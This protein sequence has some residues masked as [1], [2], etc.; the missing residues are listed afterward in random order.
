MIQMIIQ[1]QWLDQSPLINIP[2]FEDGELIVKLSKI[3]VLYIPQLIHRIRGDIKGFFDNEVRH[4]L[5]HEDL[6]EIVKAL[7]KVP[8]VEMKYSVTATNHQEEILDREVLEEGGDAIVSVNLRRTNKYNRQFVS[9]SN[10]PKPKECS[11]FLLIGNKA[12]NE[13]LAM[14]RIAFKRY[15]S[16]NLQICLPRSFVNEQLSIILMCDS[17]LGLDQEYEI[18]LN[19]INKVIRAKNNLPETEQEEEWVDPEEVVAQSTAQPQGT[20]GEDQYHSLFSNGFESF[21]QLKRQIVDDVLSDDECD[22]PKKKLAKVEEVDEDEDQIFSGGNSH[23][24]IGKQEKQIYE[25]IQFGIDMLL[26]SDEDD[27][28]RFRDDGILEK[29]MDNFF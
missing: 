25:N 18:D 9:A 13:L 16:K 15:A 29:D 24:N 12:T 7:E 8:L 27:T 6:V 21:E 23:K 28:A 5:P 14:K 26:D 19:K 22:K 10:F 2:Q 17:Y 11:W 1:G 20:E 3:G 4:R